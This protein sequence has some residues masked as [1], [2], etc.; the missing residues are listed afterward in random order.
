MGLVEQPCSVSSKVLNTSSTEPSSNES[1]AYGCGSET[2]TVYTIECKQQAA[3]ALVLFTQHELVGEHAAQ[4]LAI[5][6]LREYQDP[7]YSL[8]TL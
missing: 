6:V 1:L 8:E 7:R 4:P 5:K 3:W 2:S